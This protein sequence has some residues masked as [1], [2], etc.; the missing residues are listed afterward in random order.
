MKRE[1]WV[2][3][4]ITIIAL[5]LRFA[6]LLIGFS[7]QAN[8][9]T[10]IFPD[11]ANYL[12]SARYFFTGISS[13]NYAY[14]HNSLILSPLISGLYNIFGTT[15]LA[16][17]FLSA[18]LGAL[19]IPLTYFTAKEIFKNDKK[20]LL[21]AIFLSVSFIHRFW[22]IRALA[23][24]PLTFFFVFSIYLFIRA[25]HSEDWRWYLGA[26]I[27]TIITILIKYPG[28]LI[29]FIILIYLV[30]NIY[31]K[32]ISKK[33][34]YYYLT[35]VVIFAS[36]MVILLLSQF[37]LPFQPIDQISYYLST[38]FSG[39]SNPFF[40]IFNTLELN[41]ILGFLIFIL[42]GIVVIYSLKQHSEADILLLSW[43]AVI[44]VF[45]SFYGE[46]ELYR[47]LL[48]AFPALY[49]MLSHVIV[50]IID[51]KIK[52]MHGLSVNL[53]KVVQILAIILIIG[54]ISSELVIGEIIISERAQTYGGIYQSSEWLNS[55]G[56][57]N[58]CVM[59]PYFAQ[60]QV[61][62][63]TENNFTYSTLSG[64]TTFNDLMVD[65][66][67]K[68]VKYIIV[69]EHFPESLTLPINEILPNN[70]LNFTLVFSYLDGSFLTKLYEVHY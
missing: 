18:V 48:P 69:S 25:I 9:N 45:F 36:T 21:A 22:T 19:T 39:S 50:D 35:T 4:S 2:I 11:E 49:I 24:G 44:F 10:S 57:Q 3:L 61:E 53:R 42:I 40:Y 30:I 67:I 5:F 65:L 54:I 34:L 31:F 66:E 1:Y 47:Y 14:Y 41:L 58:D 6:S 13:P 55:N 68:N 8:L 51:N 56:L 37:I 17:R 28:I 62:F 52:I 60:A 70:P 43:L 16:G 26:G 20:A 27:S 23:D 46:S 59:M 63:Y 38:L 12:V 32:Q 29:Y 33:A 15:A 64:K 7:L